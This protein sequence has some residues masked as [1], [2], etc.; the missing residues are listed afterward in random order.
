MKF[1]NNKNLYLRRALFALLII[2]TAAFQHTFSQ[3]I[4]FMG[5]RA[6]VLIPLAVSIAVF[7]RSLGGLLFGA[8]CG[9][10]WDFATVRADGFYSVLLAC[11]GFFAGAAI[12][13]FFRN[14]IFSA[15]LL[16]A[17]AS[18]AVNVIYWFIFVFIKGY[19]GGGD[20]LFSFYLPSAL[21]TAVF[22]LFYYFAVKLIVEITKDKSRQKI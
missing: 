20:V 10:L 22:T 17:S 18:V 21:Y 3:D 16:S 7:E 2:F 8:F 9:I 19:E 4:S 13:Y 6:M 1:S 14:N 11:V 12:T 5:A 15:L